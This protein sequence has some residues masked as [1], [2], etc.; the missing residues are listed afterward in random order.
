MADDDL[1]EIAITNPVDKQVMLLAQLAKSSG[2]DGVVCSA[3]EAN[4][5]STELGKNFCL[6]T[7]GI[8]PANSSNDDQKTHNDT[9][10]Q[11]LLRVVII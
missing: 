3:K 5:L 2:L 7:P 8:R 11:L 10:P 4:H 9:R 1:K 6:V